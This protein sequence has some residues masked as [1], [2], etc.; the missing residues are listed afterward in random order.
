MSTIQ[1]NLLLANYNSQE[2]VDND[3]GSGYF[4]T[5]GGRSRSLKA[6]GGCVVSGWR[7]GTARTMHPMRCASYVW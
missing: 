5:Y 7:L 1:R 3:D 4:H 2:G 6:D